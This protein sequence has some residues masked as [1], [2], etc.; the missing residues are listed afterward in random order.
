MCLVTCSAE[1]EVYTVV[2]HLDQKWWLVAQVMT[3]SR[4]SGP[5]DVIGLNSRKF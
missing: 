4:M 3:C 1:S 2:Q 5:P